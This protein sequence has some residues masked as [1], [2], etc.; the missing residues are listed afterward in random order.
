MVRDDSGS[1]TKKVLD[2]CQVKNLHNSRNKNW[3][4]YD[5]ITEHRAVAKAET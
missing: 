5:L 4:L 1:D 3:Y 2:S